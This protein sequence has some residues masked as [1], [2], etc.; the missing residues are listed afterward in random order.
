MVTDEKIAQEKYLNSQGHNKDCGEE[1]TTRESLG[2]WEGKGKGKGSS[3]E[4]GG[5]SESD[6]E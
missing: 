2:T 1:G 5:R 3:M 4:S 6:G